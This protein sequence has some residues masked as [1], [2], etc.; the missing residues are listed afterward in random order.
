MHNIMAVSQLRLPGFHN[1]LQHVGQRTRSVPHP[2]R[3]L[4]QALHAESFLVVA[5]GPPGKA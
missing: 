3:L 4:Q 2:L 1:G 5:G